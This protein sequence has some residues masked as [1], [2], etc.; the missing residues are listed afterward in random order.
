M[1]NNNVLKVGG[2]STLHVKSGETETIHTLVNMN[3]TQNRCGQVI[4]L[5]LCG[6]G[7]R[8]IEGLVCEVQQNKTSST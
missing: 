2:C 8:W 6:R 1:C 7:N 3:W 4:D 5:Y